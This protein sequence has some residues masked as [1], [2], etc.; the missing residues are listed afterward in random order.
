MTPLEAIQVL[1]L[2][3]NVTYR[4]KEFDDV[5]RRAQIRAQ[6]EF[7]RAVPVPQ[8]ESAGAPFPPRDVAL[9]AKEHG[10][11]EGGAAAGARIETVGPR[12]GRD[13]ACPGRAHAF[14]RHEL[15]SEASGKIVGLDEPH[16][17]RTFQ[18]A[19]LGGVRSRRKGDKDGAVRRIRRQRKGTDEVHDLG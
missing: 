1:G 4:R 13:Q 19:E 17:R 5:V 6:S 10:P 14:R 8:Q 3:P 12:S 18:A 2:K 7:Q 9:P 11:L 16:A 15:A